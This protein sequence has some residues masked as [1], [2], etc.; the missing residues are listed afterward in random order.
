MCLGAATPWKS[1]ALGSSGINS[2][3]LAASRTAAIGTLGWKPLHKGR[4]ECDGSGGSV[5]KGEGEGGGVAEH[6]HM[7]PLNFASSKLAE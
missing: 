6:F 3:R 5:V 2:C 4:G 1:S 7:L